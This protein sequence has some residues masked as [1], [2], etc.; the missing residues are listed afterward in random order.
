MNTI[1]GNT[2]LLHLYL[3]GITYKSQY[4]TEGFSKIPMTFLN[5]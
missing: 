4:S 3:H 5:I 2:F 1:K